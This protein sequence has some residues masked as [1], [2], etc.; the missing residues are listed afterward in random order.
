MPAI[1]IGGIVSSYN[2]SNNAPSSNNFYDVPTNARIYHS[3]YSSG[4]KLF[5]I[6]YEDGFFRSYTY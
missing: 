3:G 4:D 5:M 6:I 1:N 2:L